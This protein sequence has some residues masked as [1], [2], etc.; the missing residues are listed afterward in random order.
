MVPGGNTLRI[1]D[2]LKHTFDYAGEI[3]ALIAADLTALVERL[4][5]RLRILDVGCGTTSMLAAFNAR[6]ARRRCHL[7]GLDIHEPT[8]AW[9]RQHGFHDDYVCADAAAAEALPDV[10]VIVAT[11]LIEHLEKP[12]ALATMAA[13]ERKAAAAVILLTPNGLI[14][15]PFTDENPFMEHRCGFRVP[16]FEALAYECRGLGGPRFM[17]GAPRSPRPITVPMLA[18]FSRAMRR[19]PRQSF[20]IL[21]RKRL[22]SA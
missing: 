16:E 10:D 17:R 5:G 1:T 20:H 12:A 13:F 7:I 4:P 19:L 21:A 6:P 15:N 2:R 22:G 3:Q 8:I 18:L 14:F 11:D 9:C